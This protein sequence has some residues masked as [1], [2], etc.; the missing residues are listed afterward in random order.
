[1]T[2]YTAPMHVTLIVP[3]P[4]STI[5][6]GYGYDRRIVA[7]LRDLGHAVAVVE[8]PGMH[9]V[10]DEAARDSACI[11]L[12]RLA[13]STRPVIDG[14]ALPAFAGLDDALAA[15]GVV[16]LIHHPTSLEPGLD[17]AVQSRLRDL[18]QRLFRRLK[19]AIVTSELTAETLAKDF[20]V[21][22]DRVAVVNPGT[23]DAPR[24][25]GSGGPTCEV[26]SIG[27]VIPR[28]GHDLL[29]R[30]LA[31]LFDL[32]WRL[33]IV[34]SEAVD[35]ACAAAL[36]ALV[37]ELGITNRVR[38]MGTAVGAALE[39][40]W[41]SA[42]IF[43][44]ATHYEGYGMVIA[45]ALKRGLPI[46]VTK[47]GAAAELLTPESGLVCPV[48]DRDQVSKSLRRLIFATDLRREIADNAWKL[49]QTLP[50]WADQ[51]ALFARALQS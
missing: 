28:K 7:G 51:A 31:R 39:E 25:P 42:D 40:I 12:D 6:G 45:E 1:M 48:D 22:P 24:A 13:P 33:T 4:F 9:P 10:T 16:G 23:D 27:T 2:R 11:A 44:L 34:G 29:L 26:L 32:D 19:G 20:G 18:E 30:A 35:P 14:L 41:Q 5:S 50:S 3:A 17:E 38:F 46:V 8:L 49:G 43:A 47:G 15:T 36:H 21:R 37:D